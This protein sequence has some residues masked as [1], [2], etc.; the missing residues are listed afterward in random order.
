MLANC[1]EIGLLLLVICQY[2]K[3]LHSRAHALLERFTCFLPWNCLG[4]CC[5][6]LGL[7]NG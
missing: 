2:L 7:T 1:V 6:P 4:F 3:H 5:Y